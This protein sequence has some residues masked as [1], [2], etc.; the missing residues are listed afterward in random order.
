M[1]ARLLKL[2]KRR[3]YITTNDA[4]FLRLTAK[5]QT[6]RLPPLKQPHLSESHALLDL[7]DR[8]RR[9]E[10]LGAGTRAVEDGVA[11]VQTH[12]VVER[13]LALRRL[14]VTRVGDPAVRLQQH[15]RAEVL[16]AVPPVGRARGA[17]AGAQDALVQTVEL[18][19][20][21]LCLA[22]LAALEGVLV[23]A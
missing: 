8:Q 3:I 15:G 9:V 12:A 11:A 21:G 2:T 17:A 19:A 6:L 18:L 16:F 7:R 14:L 22:V 1:G 5:I 10:T 20:V 13:V 23:H 4:V